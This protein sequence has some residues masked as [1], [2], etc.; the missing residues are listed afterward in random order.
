MHLLDLLDVRCDCDFF[1]VDS[2]LMALVIVSLFSQLFPSGFSVI[3]DYFGTS[4]LLSH[5]V[6]FSL[7]LGILVVD[8]GYKSDSIVLECALLLQLEPLL[9]EYIH[10][11]CHFTF[12]KEVPDEVIDY[13]WSLD[14]LRYIGFAGHV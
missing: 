3:C 11:L 5:F 6:Y 9:L 7:H 1:L 10:G 2:V 14:S 4:K 13:N 8:V 12:G